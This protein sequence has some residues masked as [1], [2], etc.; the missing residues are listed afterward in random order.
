MRVLNL[1]WSFM[2]IVYTYIMAAKM[3]LNFLTNYKKCKAK[4]NK[5]YQYPDQFESATELKS[6]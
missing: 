3:E 1:Q 5:P 6:K 4:I 2:F